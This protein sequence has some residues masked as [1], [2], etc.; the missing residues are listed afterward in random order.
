VYITTV[1]LAIVL[2]FIGSGIC[3]W[4][5]WKRRIVFPLPAWI[6]IMLMMGMLSWMYYESPER[7][8][9][10]NINLTFGWIGTTTIFCTMIVRN[11][12][13]GTLRIAFDEAQRECLVGGSIITGIW[14]AAHQFLGF[15]SYWVTFAAY[16]LVQLLGILAYRSMFRKVRQSTKKSEPVSVWI[17]WVIG[18]LVAFYPAWHSLKGHPDLFAL[19]YLCRVTISN[20]GMVYLN[21]QLRKRAKT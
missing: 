9:T 14:Y 2:S 1:T 20:S 6:L 19:T 12:V 7:S 16:C 5:V 18:N 8:W 11:I 3:A 17:I 10:S 21:L 15:T 4:H 13:D